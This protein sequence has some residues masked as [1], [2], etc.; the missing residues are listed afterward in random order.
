MKHEPPLRLALVGFGHVG[1][2]FAARL[3]GPYA[4][5]LASWGVRPRVTGIATSRHGAALDRGGLDLRR[6]L[7]L[8]RSGKGLDALHR[9]API[10]SVA[11]FIERVDADV[12]LELTTLEPRSGQPATSHVRQALA[13]GLHVVTA[14]KGPVAFAL[15]ELRRLA[16]R[17]QVLFLHE[18]AV[19][20]GTPVFNLMEPCLP[21]VRVLG[22]RGALN[23]TTN[24]MLSRMEEGATFAAALQEARRR[25][26]AEAD[27]GHDVDGWDAAVKGCVL[28]NAL[29][30]AAVRP[31]DVQRHGIRRVN[32]DR[33]RRLAREGKSLRL[34]VR[35]SRRG[36]SVRVTVKPEEVAAGDPLR[37]SGGDT[38]LLLS[39]DLAGELGVFEAQGAVDQTAY[40]LFSDLVTIVRRRRELART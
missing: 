36:R 28:A 19:M 11:D 12:L 24:L 22:F 7:G 14:N 35:G 34:V 18:G 20:D 9:G 4:R 3:L 8:V 32:P 25:G 39:T 16:R 17:H 31:P 38:I 40:A 10:R 2:R 6:C 27:A 33:L 15:R 1:R 5:V 30:G 21:G 13:R 37:T 29:M 26:I 23:A